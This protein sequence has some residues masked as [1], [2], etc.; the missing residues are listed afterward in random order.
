VLRKRIVVLCLVLLVV[1]CRFTTAQVSPDTLFPGTT[2]GY[3]SVTSMEALKQQWQKTRFG[4]LL[5]DPLMKPVGEELQ[6]QVEADWINRVGLSLD[7]LKSLP[8]GSEE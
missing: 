2:Q 1:S 8:T 6:K 3:F 5:K 4:E 7:D